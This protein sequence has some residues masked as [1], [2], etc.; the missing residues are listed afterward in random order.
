MMYTSANL[1]YLDGSGWWVWYITAAEMEKV[2]NGKQSR[3]LAVS[4]SVFI[5]CTFRYDLL[6][7]KPFHIVCRKMN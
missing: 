2:L 6:I 3:L 7:L 1:V 5:Y 4:I